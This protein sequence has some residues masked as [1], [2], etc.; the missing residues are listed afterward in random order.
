MG[1]N[2]AM[3]HALL[4]A[5]V[6]NL[7]NGPRAD[8]QPDTLTAMDLVG[9]GWRHAQKPTVSGQPAVLL[10]D[11]KFQGAFLHSLP[12]PT[13]QPL[14]GQYESL[15]RFLLKATRENP[16]DRFQTADEMADQLLGVL[17]EIVAVRSTPRPSESALASVATG[18]A[19][20]RRRPEYW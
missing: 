10:L 1:T 7:G 13:E 18:R 15:Y 12:T 9:F 17:R 5:H 19:R 8:K 3:L 2:M 6:P 20:A 14:F 4:T 11:F 16:D